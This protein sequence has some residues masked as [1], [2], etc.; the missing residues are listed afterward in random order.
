MTG[1][2]LSET[3]KTVAYGALALV[4]L[5]LT[6]FTTPHVRPVGVFS[7]RGDLL[8]PQFRDPNSAASLEVIEFDAA[9]ASVRPFKVE[10]REGRWTIPSEHNYPAD[11]K[12]RVA[13]IAAALITLRRD[14]FAS[15]N[16]A[17]YERCRVV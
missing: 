13:Q 10:N 11:A 9:S 7:E 2:A 15:D 8:F 3:N 12:D 5:C 1:I 14:D 6:W 17:D 16:S 4:L